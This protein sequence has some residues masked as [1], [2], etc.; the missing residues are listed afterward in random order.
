[1]QLAALL[2]WCGI[3][4]AKTA[5]SAP[6]PPKQA[7]AGGGCGKTHLLNGVTKYHSLTSGG[8]TRDYSIHAPASY[9]K[10]SAYP[11]VLGFHGSDSVGFFFEVDTRM[12][13]AHFSADVRSTCHEGSPELTEARYPFSRSD[14]RP[15]AG[16]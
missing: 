4:A 11:V 10:D 5:T 1:M 16:G 12:S 14:L 2:C 6:L 8:R 9:D 13:E 15:T 3:A 7:A